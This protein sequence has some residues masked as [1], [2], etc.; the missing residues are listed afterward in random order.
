VCRR[1]SPTTQHYIRQPKLLRRNNRITFSNLSEKP[2]KLVK[3]TGSHFPKPKFY[4]VGCQSARR[5]NR[6]FP[7]DQ[8]P[9][10]PSVG[11]QSNRMWY[12]TADGVLLYFRGTTP[13][14]KEFI[15]KK[16]NCCVQNLNQRWLHFPLPNNP[17]TPSSSS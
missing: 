4:T 6:L 16:N 15:A 11:I 1:L 10:E 3:S 17:R 2:R 14:H 8:L 5:S 13:D 7:R 12:W 9:D